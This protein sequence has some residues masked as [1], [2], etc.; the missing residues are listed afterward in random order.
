MELLKGEMWTEMVSQ[1]FQ[2]CLG[3]GALGPTAV[4]EWIERVWRSALSS[5]RLVKLFV[6]HEYHRSGQPHVH[7]LWHCMPALSSFERSA[8]KERLG[9][10]VGWVRVQAFTHGC[11]GEAYCVKR[12]ALYVTK[13]SRDRR[14]WRLKG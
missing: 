2:P 6:G 4:L 14:R 8:L 10:L 7:A 9:R 1:S 12:A 3:M 13:G 5:G 11:G